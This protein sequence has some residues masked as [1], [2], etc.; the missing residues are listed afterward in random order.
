MRVVELRHFAER[1]SSFPITPRD[2]HG[3]NWV[4]LGRVFEAVKRFDMQ[5]H[6][7]E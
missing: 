2:I 3:L 4:E 5:A 7:P 1:D 6:V